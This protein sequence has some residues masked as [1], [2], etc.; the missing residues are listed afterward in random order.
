MVPFRRPAILRREYFEQ[1]IYKL[2]LAG[3]SETTR[4]AASAH[5]K[6]LFQ[7]MG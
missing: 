6:F 5:A 2:Q 4:T 7:E 1:V 3:R